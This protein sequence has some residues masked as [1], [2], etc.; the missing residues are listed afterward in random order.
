MK[1]R[2]SILAGARDLANYAIS[3]EEAQDAFIEQLFLTLF[4]RAAL[5]MVPTL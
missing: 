5:P 3:S 2:L 4:N 1:T